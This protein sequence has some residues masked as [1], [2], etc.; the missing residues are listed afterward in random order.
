MALEDWILQ[1]YRPYAQMQV[2][3]GNRVYRLAMN[4]TSWIANQEQ[5]LVSTDAALLGEE[6]GAVIGPTGNVSSPGVLSPPY[7][8]AGPGQAM[9]LA[10]DFAEPQ[11]PGQQYG[12]GEVM[13]LVW[14]FVVPLPILRWDLVWDFVV[15]PPP[16]PGAGD[17][18]T[19]ASGDEITTA[20]GDPITT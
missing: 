3:K 18:I 6:L 15:P 5:S 14:D 13:D 2:V 8:I 4:G 1:N 20:S 12:F 19:T 7:A 16:A 10:W 17:T 9:T 11:Q